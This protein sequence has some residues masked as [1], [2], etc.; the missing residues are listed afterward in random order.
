MLNFCVH[1]LSSLK[2]P[3]L[4]RIIDT[5]SSNLKYDM[6]CGVLWPL[7]ALHFLPLL[8]PFPVL[9]SS[10]SH[11][12]MSGWW[13][14]VKQS[15]STFLRY[16]LHMSWLGDISKNTVLTKLLHVRV[17]PFKV[18]PTRICRLLCMSLTGLEASIDT[19]VWV[20]KLTVMFCC[21]WLLLTEIGSFEQTFQSAEK[22]KS[23]KTRSGERAACVSTCTSFLAKKW[24]TEVTLCTV[25]SLHAEGNHSFPLLCPYW[26]FDAELLFCYLVLWCVYEWWFLWC[27]RKPAL[28]F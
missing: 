24:Q 14:L 25:C 10:P 7:F 18:I 21:G 27:W 16:L 6:W 15:L 22:K 3:K 12:I 8:P 11:R 28:C 17:I 4:T 2:V 26:N 19:I 5:G 13:C 1:H 23:H 9:S 20:L